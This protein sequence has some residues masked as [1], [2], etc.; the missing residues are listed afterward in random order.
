MPVLDL[1]GAAAEGLVVV[2]GEAALIVPD[3]V[4]AAVAG[5]PA[6]AAAASI[7]F[8]AAAVVTVD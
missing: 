2:V 8:T 7:G 5:L 4:R 1:P 6:D 3:L